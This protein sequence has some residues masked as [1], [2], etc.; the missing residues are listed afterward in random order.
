MILY[1]SGGRSPAYQRLPSH[2]DYVAPSVGSVV[3]AAQDIPLLGTG[4]VYVYC[5]GSR[6]DFTHPRVFTYVSK[7]ITITG[8]SLF[9]PPAPVVTL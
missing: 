1:V 9:S 3:G 5:G 4:V 7:G 6:I 2:G 8:V